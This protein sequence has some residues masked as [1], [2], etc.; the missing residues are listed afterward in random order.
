MTTHKSFKRTVRE[1]MAK[2]GER[3]SAA[4]AQL[5]PVDDAAPAPAAASRRRAGAR[6]R[7]AHVA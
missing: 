2:T 5:L 6:V 3:Y 4:R 1:R 7:A